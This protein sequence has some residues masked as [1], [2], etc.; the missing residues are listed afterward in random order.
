MWIILNKSLTDAKVL[1]KKILSTSGKPVALINKSHY[2]CSCWT[3]VGVNRD[4]LQMNTLYV[5]KYHK[6]TF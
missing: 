6:E 5:Y 2:I 3:V 1:I 4:L